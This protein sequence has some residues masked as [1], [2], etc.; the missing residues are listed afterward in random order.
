M[1][2]SR[3]QQ[4]H[5]KLLKRQQEA[6]LLS[7]EERNRLREL[8]FP[9]K[10]YWVVAPAA[11]VVALLYGLHRGIWDG[12]VFYVPDM[13]AP[14]PHDPIMMCRYLCFERWASLSSLK[15]SVSKDFSGSRRKRRVGFGEWALVRNPVL[16]G[17]S[18]LGVQRAVGVAPLRCCA[19][20]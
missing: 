4:H 19:C 9:M 15:R 8:V 10:R 6:E 16:C 12:V 14:L 20:T 13:N 3:S 17:R 2:E 18:A 7:T 1:K 5:V 11:V